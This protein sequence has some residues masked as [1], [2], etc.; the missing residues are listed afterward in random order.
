MTKALFETIAS[1]RL[2]DVEGGQDPVTQCNLL[3]WR[4]ALERFPDN[5]SWWERFRGAPDPNAE[6][7]FNWYR[8]NARGCDNLTPA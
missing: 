8:A 4:W 1:E 6:P 3:Y 7:R 2:A 5:R